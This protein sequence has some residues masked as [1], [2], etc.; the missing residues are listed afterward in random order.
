MASV[1]PFIAPDGVTTVAALVPRADRCLPV[2]EALQPLLR[3]G[4]LVRGQVVGVAGSAGLSL[5]TAVVARAAVTG[6]WVAVVGVEDFGVEAAA[7]LG[8]PLERLV[9]V[10]A[11]S[12]ALDWADRIAAC[13][14]GFE[15][16]V[17]THPRRPAPH[18]LRRVRQR[19]QAHGSVLVL[20]DPDGT[21]CDVLLTAVDSRWVGIGAGHGAL[22]ARSVQVS[23]TGRR[24]PQAVQR[25]VWLP[26]HA[27]RLGGIQPSAT[28][29]RADEN[30]RSLVS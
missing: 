7:G 21:T 20:I 28:E 25:R 12:S 16:V 29:E 1:V 4:G 19:L 9:S 27:G 2:D 8:L 17:T 22:L 23:A 11:G 26:D 10:D 15:L 14:D 18:L 24:H 3:D 13:A 5:A 6:S 30:R